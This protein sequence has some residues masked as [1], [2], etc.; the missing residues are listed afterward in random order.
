MAEFRFA[1]DEAGYERAQRERKT[2]EL[3]R[4][5]NADANGDHGNEE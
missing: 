2:H 1:E 3:G 4:I 5:P